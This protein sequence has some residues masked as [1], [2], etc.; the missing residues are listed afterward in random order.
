LKKIT[1]T[2]ENIEYSQFVDEIHQFY[3]KIHPTLITYKGKNLN[4][5]QPVSYKDNFNIIKKYKEF[6]EEMERFRNDELS[7]R[8]KYSKKCLIFMMTSAIESFKHFWLQFPLAPYSISEILNFNGF[9]DFTFR[10]HED[11]QNY[12][13]LLDNLAKML[14]NLLIFTKSQVEKGILI[15]KPELKLVIPMWQSFAISTEESI[16]MVSDTRLT[17]YDEKIKIDFIDTLKNKVLDQIFPRFNAIVNYLQGEYQEKAPK[18]V[19]LWQYPGGMAAYLNAIKTNISYEWSPEQIHQLGLDQVQFLNNKIEKIMKMNNIKGNVDTISN[20]INTN[21]AYCNQPP[22]K[23]KERFDKFLDAMKEFIP[24]IFK[25]QP[26]APGVT[27]RL[28]LNLEKSMTFG[29]YEP[30]S[31]GRKEGK[32]YYN[33]SNV[34]GKS[35]LR[36]PA[37]A[38]HELYPGHHFQIMM[39]MENE[40]LD[41]FQ[42]MG[43]INSYNEGWA[44]YA[45]NLGFEYKIVS[46]P[47]DIIGALFGRKMKAI[48][49]VVDTGLNYFKWSLEKARKYMRENHFGNESII[50]TESLRY[51]CDLPSQA[52]AYSIGFLQIQKIREEIKKQLGDKFDIKE[53]HEAILEY[54]AQP[55]TILEEHIKRKLL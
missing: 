38:L 30:P 22:D 11:L 19:G 42:K 18:T 12:L 13:H 31:S 28:P 9:L 10:N 33:A 37:I 17:V 4:G 26:K 47:M 7:D 21:P 2:K 25:T 52:L 49:L 1:P 5:F 15:P 44:E 16:M 14:E 45:S 51:S 48:R 41:E 6:L 36:I 23:I 8:Q 46:D 32:Y 54:G 43:F 24:T 29:Y 27:E 39:N 20:K 40:C 55:L 50:K 34:G 35:Y 53:F 3:L